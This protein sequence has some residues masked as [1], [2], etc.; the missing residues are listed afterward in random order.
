MSQL[1]KTRLLCLETKLMKSY[2]VVDQFHAPAAVAMG[3]D[4]RSSIL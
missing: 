2:E 4:W 3:R 1:L